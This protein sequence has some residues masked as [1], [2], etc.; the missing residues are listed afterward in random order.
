MYHNKHSINVGSYHF[1][2]LLLFSRWHKI[3]VARLP[4]V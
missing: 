3:W 4:E 2:T 1:Y